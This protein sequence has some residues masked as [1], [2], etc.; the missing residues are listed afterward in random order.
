MK[1]IIKNLKVNF[2]PFLFYL[3]FEIA[4]KQCHIQE[5]SIEYFIYKKI[6]YIVINYLL[7]Q[8]FI[9]LKKA[10]DLYEKKY[11]NNYYNNFKYYILYRCY[12]NSIIKSISVNKF[13]DLILLYFNKISYLELAYTLH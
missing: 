13:N 11:I 5:D 3:F 1:K 10:I 4:C 8:F 12:K 9:Y 7:I 6:Y 2:V